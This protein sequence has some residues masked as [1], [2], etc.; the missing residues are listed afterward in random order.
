MIKDGLNSLLAGGSLSK[1]SGKAPLPQGIRILVAHENSAVRKLIRKCLQTLGATAI[2]DL[3]PAGNILETLLA[4]NVQ[5]LFCNG[6]TPEMREWGLVKS[7]REHPA[8]R[9]A[10]IVVVS[11]NSD[12]EAI[13]GAVQAGVDDYVI[14]PFSI[15]VFEDK[16]RSLFAR[17]PA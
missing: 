10:K 13:L 17:K 2:L 16:V 12:K 5:V 15:A 7:I 6:E 11:G 1:K 4:E 8:A 3:D 9:S 14:I